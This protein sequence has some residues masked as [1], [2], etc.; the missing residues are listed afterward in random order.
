[1]HGKTSSGREHYTC[2]HLDTLVSASV[3]P[4]AHASAVRAISWPLKSKAALATKAKSAARQLRHAEPA[5]VC[6]KRLETGQPASSEHRVRLAELQAQLKHGRSSRPV[7][8]RGNTPRAAM[9][10]PHT[11]KQPTQRNE[12]RSRGSRRARA[13]RLTRSM[14]KRRPSGSPSR[15]RLRT[16]P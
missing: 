15:G 8:R 10:N 1:M 4:D 13:A 9:A 7:Q 12:L 14:A 5:S 2:L 11:A 3:R 6:A 16:P